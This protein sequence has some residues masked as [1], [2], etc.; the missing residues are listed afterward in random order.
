VYGRTLGFFKI[1]PATSL[2]SP[3]IASNGGPFVVRDGKAWWLPTG[4]GYPPPILG[5]TDL[6]TATPGEPVRLPDTP[7]AL[8]NGV[9][10]L[11]VAVPGSLFPINPSTAA[12]EPGTKVG[13]QPVS[14]AV[15]AGSVWVANAGPRGS[16]LRISPQSGEVKTIDLPHSPVGIAVGEGLIWVAVGSP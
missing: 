7:I 4:Y 15:G 13:R 14:V 11:W 9:H 5:H 8:A 12:A 16:V 3:P 2:P 1:R 6:L 10:R